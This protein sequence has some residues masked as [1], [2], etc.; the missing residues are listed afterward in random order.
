MDFS[1]HKPYIKKKKYFRAFILLPKIVE[2]LL[3]PFVLCLHSQF[4]PL[5]DFVRR[6]AVEVVD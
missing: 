6:L 4:L 5:L 2:E 1:A 3:F